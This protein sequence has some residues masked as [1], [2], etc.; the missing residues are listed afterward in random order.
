V[1]SA[2]SPL[3]ALATAILPAAVFITG[4][5]PTVQPPEGV[6]PAELV[7]RSGRIVT[8]DDSAPEAQALAARDGTIVA[9]RSRR[10]ALEIGPTIHLLATGAWTLFMVPGTTA[11]S[12]EDG[13]KR[14]AG[15]NGIPARLT[16]TFHLLDI[17]AG[18]S[19]GPLP[20][21][22][23]KAATIR[24]LVFDRDGTRRSAASV[25]IEYPDL[26]FART[27][28]NFVSRRTSDD[29]DFEMR[30]VVPRVAVR[31]FAQHQGRRSAV[32]TVVLGAGEEH[33]RLL[34]LE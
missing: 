27:L 15:Y 21:R 12:F 26:P 17:S 1:I 3:V 5:G 32:S 6:T 29:A 18:G 13:S 10:S 9:V 20:I 30:N 4:C 7:L 33:N 16:S 23:M 28:A 34:L 11:F 25:I 2:R 31:V 8:L 24:G 19:H 22:L 14:T